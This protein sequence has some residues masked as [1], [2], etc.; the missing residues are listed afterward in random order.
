M[1]APGSQALDLDS[2]SDPPSTACFS[3][4]SNLTETDAGHAAPTARTLAEE[5]RRGCAS[6]RGRS[7]SCA[8]WVP[9]QLL[10][11]TTGQRASR[12]TQPASVILPEGQEEGMQRGGRGLWAQALGGRPDE[13]LG[14][15][16]PSVQCAGSAVCQ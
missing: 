4:L 1:V 3:N 15:A 8:L 9:G 5:R 7:R 2:A 16:A 14:L 10:T 12:K 11:P 13:G 6:G